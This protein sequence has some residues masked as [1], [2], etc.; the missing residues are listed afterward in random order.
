MEALS[1]RRHIGRFR[2]VRI[3]AK[4]C[5]GEDR[6]IPGAGNEWR[7]AGTTASTHRTQRSHR[8]LNACS[9][10]PGENSPFGGRANPGYG[11]DPRRAFSC[12]RGPT[13][14]SR[15]ARVAGLG[16][17]R[18]PAFG[19]LATGHANASAIGYAHCGTRPRTGRVHAAI[20]KTALRISSQSGRDASGAVG[21]SRGI[22][23]V[24][25]PPRAHPAH[26]ATATSHASHAPGTIHTDSPGHIGFGKSAWGVYA[27][28]SESA[29]RT[30]GTL[31]AAAAGGF[32]VAKRT[33]RV[34]AHLWRRNACRDER[35]PCGAINSRTASNPGLVAGI[36]NGK[37]G[38]APETS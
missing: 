22:H 23:P 16:I 21:R 14:M 4:S 25:R 27:L 18:A 38:A 3:A 8:R 30:L 34:H 24:I 37:L 19:T 13:G 29:R 12:H 32:T 1:S 35:P 9:A 6:R 33:G 2:H 26:S 5:G 17:D 31:A 7:S 15:A 36:V 10:I 20:S 11:G 28:V